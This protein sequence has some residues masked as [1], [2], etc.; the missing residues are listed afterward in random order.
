MMP[1]VAAVLMAGAIVEIV[2]TGRHAP[3]PL[4]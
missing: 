3:L 4:V 2:V 1:A